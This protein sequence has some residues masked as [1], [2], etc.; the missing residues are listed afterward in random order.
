MEDCTISAPRV[1]QWRCSRPHARTLPD[2]GICTDASAL[3]EPRVPCSA[4]SGQAH[5]AMVFRVFAGAGAHGAALQ[6]AGFLEFFERAPAS[7]A[8]G[9]WNSGDPGGRGAFGHVAGSGAC[10]HRPLSVIAGGTFTAAG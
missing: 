7:V 4:L 6:R 5:A 2:S 8:G 10:L 1:T 3:A 9:S